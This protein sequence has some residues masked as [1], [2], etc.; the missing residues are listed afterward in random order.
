VEGEP[1]WGEARVYRARIAAVLFLFSAVCA[2]PSAPAAAPQGP[3]TTQ[4]GGGQNRERR[5]GVGGTITAV[6]DKSITLKTLD[7]R[8]VTVN[9]TEKTQYRKDRQPAKFSDFKVGEMVFAAGQ[10]TGENSWQA[11]FVAMRTGAG[12]EFR[13]GLGK[14]FIA[15]EIKAIEG[16]RLTIA[17]P[18]GVTQTISVDE[19]TSFR[20]QRES[21]TL[22]DI[23]PGDQVFG[24]GEMK[25]DVFVAATLT[26]GEPGMMRMGEPDQKWGEGP[27]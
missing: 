14:R 2:A 3:I 11:D 1:F 27:R 25:N 18:D 6:D 22:I 12:Q 10:S 16:T 20:K 5:P 15:G 21:I 9:V 19:N 8:T 17:R 13:E 7:G 4:Q 24:R 23:K 26:V